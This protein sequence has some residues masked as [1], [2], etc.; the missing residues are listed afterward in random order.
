MHFLTSRAR[1]GQ[2]QDTL[3]LSFKIFSGGG[4]LISEIST[5][6]P[7]F[8]LLKDPRKQIASEKRK[9][10]PFPSQCHF[11]K[12]KMKMNSSWLSVTL[13]LGAAQEDRV[14]TEAKLSYEGVQGQSSFFVVTT[15]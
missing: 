12:Q 6:V 10:G 2:I 4:P 11:Q 13:G 8:L 9:N 14:N 5:G 15:R 7:L 3:F 1:K